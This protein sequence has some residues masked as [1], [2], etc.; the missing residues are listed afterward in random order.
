MFLRPGLPPTEVSVGQLHP[1]TSGITL[2]ILR[3]FQGIGAT[4][5]TRSALGTLAHAFFPS[6]IAS[7]AFRCP[8]KYHRRIGAP[9]FTRLQQRLPLTGISGMISFDPNVAS[10]EAVDWIGASVVTV[11]LVLIVFTLG[12]GGRVASQGWK[13][14]S[15]SSSVS[16]IAK[17]YNNFRSLL[18]I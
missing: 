8:R 7:A 18:P 3:A 9:H 4:A 12:Q 11:G 5:A 14:P 17:L 6:G 2:I 15:K 10:T 13:T 16:H 1:F